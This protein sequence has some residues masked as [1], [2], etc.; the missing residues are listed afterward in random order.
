MFRALKYLKK[1]VVMV[2]FPTR[3][4]SSRARAS[5]R[6]ASNVCA[7][8]WAGSTSI[9]KA[10]TATP[11]RCADI[12][13]SCLALCRFLRAIIAPRV[14]SGSETHHARCARG[15]GAQGS[16]GGASAGRARPDHPAHERGMDKSN[17][18]PNSESRNRGKVVLERSRLS[19]T[20]GR[21][22]GFHKRPS[23]AANGDYRVAFFRQP[24]G[25][26]VDLAVGG[27]VAFA[28]RQ[29]RGA[30]R[31]DGAGGGQRRVPRPRRRRRLAAS[32]GRR[33]ALSF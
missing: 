3:R 28:R 19:R 31:R 16:T 6:T 8:S 10:R 1:P 15:T 30:V 13:E 17:G 23:Q 33:P 20:N 22:S 26:R 18:R 4:T 12:P 24:L 27:G 29:H 14:T 2:R 21:V 5:P 11:T 25:G 32:P 7:T 9:C